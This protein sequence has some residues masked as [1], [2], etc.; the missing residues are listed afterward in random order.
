MSMRMKYVESGALI[1]YMK[2]EFDPKTLNWSDFRLKLVGTTDP[3]IAEKESI[4]GTLFTTWESLGLPSE[5]DNGDNGIHASASPFEA[6]GERMNWC[7]DELKS[8]PFGTELL[9]RGISEDIIRAWAKDPQVVIDEDGNTGS[10]FDALE[11]LDYE[12]CLNSLLRLKKL[13]EPKKSDEAQKVEEVKNENV[14]ET[15][16]VVDTPAVAEDVKE[17]VKEDT[18][19]VTMED[20]PTAT[21][22]AK[23]PINAEKTEVTED[24]QEA[25]NADTPKATEAIDV[26]VGVDAEREIDDTKK[27]EPATEIEDQNKAENVVIEDA[28]KDVEPAK[29]IDNEKNGDNVKVEAV[30]EAEPAKDADNETITENTSNAE[31]AEKAEPAKKIDSEKE[32]DN[33]VIAATEPEKETDNVTKTDIVAKAKVAEESEPVKKVHIKKKADKVVKADV[34]KEPD[35]TQHAETATNKRGCII[36]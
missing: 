5:L 25:I 27:A 4:R 12:E 18:P 15:I 29:K 36:A 10:L 26:P 7:G 11:D 33:V 9:E 32:A 16:E 21:E 34:A 19:E 30:E 17:P 2:V 23:E 35:S 13:N 8:D 6:L 22:D 14:K 31:A 3:S 20:K 28:A 24:N 1:Y